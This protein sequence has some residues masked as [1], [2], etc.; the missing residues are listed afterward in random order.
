MISNREAINSD[1][2]K[3]IMTNAGY[4]LINDKVNQI[5]LLSKLK[6]FSNLGIKFLKANKNENG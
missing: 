5:N 4:L 3:E 1:K 2:F 6:L